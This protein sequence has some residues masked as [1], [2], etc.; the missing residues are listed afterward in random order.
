M[1]TATNRGAVLDA[2]DR[3][4]IQDLY[5]W[6]ALAVDNGDAAGWAECFTDD[7]RFEIA[8]DEAAVATGREQIQ[9]FGQA[10]IDSPRSAVRHHVT[11]LSVRATDGGA[12]GS[13][14]AMEVLGVRP[15]SSVRYDDELVKDGDGTWRFAKRVVTVFGIETLD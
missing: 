6:Y 10:H 7:A 15:I 8:G 12:V 13:A 4:E 1:T 14:Y 3:L 11:T 5:G 9:A 2:A